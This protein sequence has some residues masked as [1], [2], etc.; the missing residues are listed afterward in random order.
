MLPITFH[1]DKFG[2]FQ[3]GKFKTYS[4]LEALDIQNTLGH[5]PNWNFNRETFDRC[6]WFLE[7]Q[8]DIDALYRMRARQIRDAYDYVVIFFSGGSDSNNI[9]QSFLNAD[10][11]IDELATFTTENVSEQG[12]NRNYDWGSELEL[13]VNPYV[14][15]LKQQGHDFKFRQIYTTDLILDYVDQVKDQY[16]YYTNHCLSPNNP[17]KA[18]LR[19]RIDDYKKIIDSGKKLCF[20]HGI[21]KPYIKVKD[22][23]W[24]FYFT[25]QLDTC[26]S[27]YVQ[28]KYDQGWYDELFFWSP[29]MPEIPIKQAHMI[30]RFCDTV[31][32]PQF[33]QKAPS[34]LGYNRTLDMYVSLNTSR[35]L[36][37]PTTWNSMIYQASKSRHSAIRP[38]FGNLAFSERDGWFF[39]SQHEFVKKYETGIQDYLNKLRKNNFYN[40]HEEDK[41][42]LTIVKQSYQEHQFA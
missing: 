1:A 37:Y 34:K 20:V 17:F 30:K 16:F 26:V 39:R 33:Y 18:I 32:D 24:F 6:N 31:M 22:N 25:D 15:K 11:K 36:L 23:K 21:E 19:E 7:P 38:G 29:D 9:L 4:K 10:C 5:W 12:V 3:V 8:S 40:W 14:K 27:P 28:M 41:S 2:Y 42:S 35:T 13:V